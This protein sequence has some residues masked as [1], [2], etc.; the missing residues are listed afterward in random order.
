MARGVTTG[1]KARRS[2]TPSCTDSTWL[3]TIFTGDAWWTS[4]IGPSASWINWAPAPTY[5]GRHGQGGGGPM[6]RSPSIR[7]ACLGWRAKHSPGTRPA[8]SF[9]TGAPATAR[10]SEPAICGPHFVGCSGKLYL[11]RGRLLHLC[12]RLGCAKQERRRNPVSYVGS[13]P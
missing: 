8:G 2:T 5:L 12:R 7:P 9:Q 11:P 4:W 1:R 6:R 10:D 13:T 3:E